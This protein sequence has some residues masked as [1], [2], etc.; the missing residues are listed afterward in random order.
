MDL[1]PVE[2]VHEV[3][4]HAARALVGEHRKSATNVALVCSDVYNLVSPVLYHTLVVSSRNDHKFPLGKDFTRV[5]QHVRYMHISGTDTNST[6]AHDL[7]SHWN[8]RQGSNAFLDAPWAF[9]KDFVLLHSTALRGVRIINM[10]LLQGLCRGPDRLLDSFCLNLTHLIA[11]IPDDDWSADVSN[12]AWVH[13]MLSAAPA[14]TH[15]VLLVVVEEPEESEESEAYVQIAHRSSHA[16]RRLMSSTT[17]KCACLRVAGHIIC[18]AT[19]A[20]FADLVE[21]LQDVRLR[22]WF[23]PRLTEV[24]M[25]IFFP[26]VESPTVNCWDD[27]DNRLATED[28]LAGR[29]H[30][31]PEQ[32]P[33]TEGTVYQYTRTI[34]DGSTVA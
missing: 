17:L 24:S 4:L 22:I 12:T 9:T 6:I 11:Y 19:E 1:L 18:A 26:G 10:T 34:S 20:V 15:L 13:E 2:I 3:L 25:S 29:D 30:W 31:S 21:E 14:L 33:P 8:P 16:V 5:L 7:L 23:D 27:L 28:S 32:R